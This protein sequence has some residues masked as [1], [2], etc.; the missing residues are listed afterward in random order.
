MEWLAYVAGGGGAVGAIAGA[1]LAARAFANAKLIATVPPT[2]LGTLDAGLHEVR[3]TIVGEDALVSPVARR[4][5]A[6]YRF[7]VE[8]LRGGRWETVTDVREARPVAL[9]DG[10]GR[11]AVDLLAADVVAV[12]PSRARSGVL[13]APGPELA[14]LFDRVGKPERAPAGPF[15]R[16]HEETL[17]HGDA[18]YV[19]GTAREADG[20]WEIG[21]ASGA[22]FV[23][24]DRDEAEV[25]RHQRRAGRR[26]A[27]M[28][29]VGAMAM[30]WGVLQ[31]A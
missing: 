21:P 6:Y 16:W 8:E 30:T 29:V 17:A 22:P 1:A 3:G 14:E 12:Q 25:V 2:P 31:L 19:V 26:W 7:L 11:A 27:A 28:G 23:V 24:S 18:V 10:T 9:E 5:C 4:P 15:V 20:A 13:A